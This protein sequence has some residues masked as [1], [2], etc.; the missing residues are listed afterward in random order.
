MEYLWSIYGVSMEYLW[1]IY[2]VSMEYLWSIYGVSMDL[3]VQV[4]RPKIAI[5]VIK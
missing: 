5:Q 1:S 3:T 2:G 4:T